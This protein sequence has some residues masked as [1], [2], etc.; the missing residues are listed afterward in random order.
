[1]DLSSI[2]D[3]ANSAADDIGR[4]TVSSVILSPEKMTTDVYCIRPLRW[5]SIPYGEERIDEV[6]DDKRGIYAFSIY[7]QNDALPPHGYIM[8]IG[9]AGR[10]SN[11]S[12]KA[13]YK[14]YLN[15]KKVIKRARIARM[16]GHWSAVLNFCF[17]E[18]G[19]DVSSED[20]ELLEKQL[21]TA[22]V[23]PFSEGDIEADTK[24][25]RRAF[26]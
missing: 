18:V 15:E 10:K 8:Y 17:A 20:L 2:I 11:R 24:Q 6:P 16:I 7:V 19:D 13:R 23:P 21:N 5:K 26:R 25:K 12:L 4:Y 3:F 22:L 9:I 1:M 14:D